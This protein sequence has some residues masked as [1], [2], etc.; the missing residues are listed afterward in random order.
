MPSTDASQHCCVSRCGPA[1]RRGSYLAPRTLIFW[2]LRRV[3]L[4]M[5]G[6]PVPHG[7]LRSNKGKKGGGIANATRKYQAVDREKA[8]GVYVCVCGVCVCGVCVEGRVPNHSCQS[9]VYTPPVQD[10]TP[11]L[12]PPPPSPHLTLFPKAR[13]QPP[14]CCQF[15]AS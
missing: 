6:V 4:K 13:S 11:P 14:R 5:P 3:P 2:P 12:F 9:Y 1:G 7:E 15:S 10:L 8:R